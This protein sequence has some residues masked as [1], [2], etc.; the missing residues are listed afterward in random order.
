MLERHHLEIIRAVDQQGTLTEAANLLCLT[1]SALSHS[2]KKLEQQLGVQLW[3]KRGRN[4]KLS[5]SGLRILSLANRLLPQFEH[6]ELEMQDIVAGQKGTLRIGMEC[7]PCFQWLLKVVAPFLKQYPDVDVDIRKEFQFGGLGALLS[8]DID[9]LITPDPL[10]KQGLDYIPVFDYEQVLVV[11]EQHRFADK[12]CIS[13]SE[14]AE[15]TLL[16]YPIEI[17][18]LDIFNEFITPAG[19]CVKKHKTIENTEIMLQMVNANRGVAALPAWL[20]AEFQQQMPIKAVRL[21]KNGVHKCIYIGL[22]SAEQRPVYLE[23][24]IHLAKTSGQ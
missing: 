13:A 4:L 1:Q 7:S 24:L 20:V 14:L 21:G 17:S 12:N 9:L 11:S 18:R 16:T 3:Q 5:E 22:R 10:H 23:Q 8:Y 2:I 19:A 6:A 15:E